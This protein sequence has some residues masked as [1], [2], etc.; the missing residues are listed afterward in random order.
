MRARL[1]PIWLLATILAPLR[2]ASAQVP[3]AD[4]AFLVH[5]SQILL[6]AVTSGDSS[7][8]STHLASE[9][10]LS[11]EEGHHV[12]RAEFLASL[13][14]LPAGQTGKL[15]MA[16]VHLVGSRDVAV[17]SYDAEEEHQYYGQLLRTTFHTTDTWIRRNGRWLQLASHVTALPR[18]VP[19]VSVSEKLLAEYAGTYHLTPDIALSLAATPAGLVLRRAGRPDQPLRA[20]N[21][22]IF[23]RDG[24]R[25]F[26]TFERD[27]AGRVTEA[28]NWRD[29][30]PV[31]WTRD[32]QP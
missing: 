7:A 27:T 20:L 11:D 2:P 24:I 16:N 31:S 26:W 13:G 6:D 19:G 14:P 22:R 10:F 1:I 12:P 5:A 9:W 21:A 28:V 30:N 15:V 29:N 25:G 18:R 32:Q 4:S 17:I 3:P 8:W 23:V